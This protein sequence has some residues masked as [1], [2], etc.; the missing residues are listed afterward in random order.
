MSNKSVI[1]TVIEQF[2]RDVRNGGMLFDDYKIKSKKIKY[3]IDLI[4]D[5]K[6]RLARCLLFMHKIEMDQY[7]DLKIRIDR[8]RLYYK[9]LVS[10]W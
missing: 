10:K 3:G 7:I 1:L 9:R 4:F 2:R 6:L 8:S 5:E